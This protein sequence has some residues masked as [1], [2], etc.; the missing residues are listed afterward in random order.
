MNKGNGLLIQAIF[1]THINMF[2]KII[3]DSIKEMHND[4]NIIRLT[5]VTSFFHSIVVMF[6]ILLNINN[7][8]SRN[9]EDWLYI[10][11]V[12]SYFVEAINRN[13]FVFVV[14][15]I[16]AVCFLIYSITYPIWQ[17]AT[18]HYLKDRKG[19][20]NALKKWI[21]DFFPTY[22]FWFI[23]MILSPIVFFVVAFRVYILN[24]DPSTL[25]NV[26][27]I[28]WFLVMN[29]LNT[30][31]T[32]VRYCISIDWLPLYEAFKKSFELN[33][34]NIRNAFRYKRIQLILLINFS[35]NTILMLG[36][37]LLL[38]YIAISYNIMEIWRVRVSIY[39]IFFIMAML[40]AYMS[41]FIRAFFV[42]YRYKLYQNITKKW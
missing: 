37:P 2:K 15:M 31:K 5:F 24:W 9:Y 36:I 29:I 39:L 33:L 20:K 26:S 8:I 22:E 10:W 3:K 14:I 35:I 30:L 19:I 18:I 1:N 11:K 38:M 32:Y 25:L 4:V 7:L 27:M 16:T 17:A 6:L 34:K 42:Y 40:W 23:S 41:S 13:H 21:K 12:A 28:M